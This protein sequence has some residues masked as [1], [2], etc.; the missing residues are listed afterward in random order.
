MNTIHLQEADIELRSRG[1]SVYA[2][3][4]KRRLNKKGTYPIRIRL[5]HKSTYRDYGTR[6]TT[7]EDTWNKILLKR[8]KG[9]AADLKIK[10]LAL[11]ERAFD[12]LITIDPFSFDEFNAL[13]MN[14]Q[15]ND[16]NNVFNWYHD[17]IKELKKN[18]QVGTASS[19][20]CSMN[21]LKDFIGVQEK[22]TFD[23][24]YSRFLRKY[25]KWAYSNGKSP[26]TV[27]IYLRPLRHLFNLASKYVKEYPFNDYK[28]PSPRNIKKALTLE[29]IKSIYQYEAKEGRPEA[30]YRD[31][32]MFSYFANGINMKDI[33]RL[34]YSNIKGNTIEFRRAKTARTIKRLQAHFDSIDR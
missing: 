18:D 11:L 15:N 22:L 30:F 3:L 6:Q 13:Y 28:I 27:G 1:I 16:R 23:K 5:T 21:S 29:Q 12:I 2:H 32:W 14:K 10:I 24:S 26:T 31:I 9:D 34:Q 8:P 7:D 19:Y 17:K 33:C 4:D 20:E 25:E